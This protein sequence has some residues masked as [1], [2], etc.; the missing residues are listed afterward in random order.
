MSTA[1]ETKKGKSTRKIFAC[2]FMTLDGVIQNEE[3]IATTISECGYRSPHST[4]CFGLCTKGQEERGQTH[5][6]H[7][8]LIRVEIRISP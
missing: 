5:L 1:V 4:V 3:K 7:P 2:E 6:P 8:E